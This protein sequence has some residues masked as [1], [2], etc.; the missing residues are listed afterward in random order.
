MNVHVSTCRTPDTLQQVTISI[1][2]LS[3]YCSLPRHSKNSINVEKMSIPPENPSCRSPSSI[4]VAVLECE[5]M[6]G[7]IVQSHGNFTRIFKQ[8][9]QSGV[10]RVNSA[11]SSRKRTAL[12]FSRFPVLDGVYPGDISSF[13]AIIITGSTCSAYDNLPWINLL[14]KYIRGEHII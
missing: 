14:T 4:H 13:H 3:A 2:V 12:K 11:R 8:W 6:P 9:L 7:S 1:C 5:R 10:K